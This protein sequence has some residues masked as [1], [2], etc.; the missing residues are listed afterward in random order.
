MSDTVHGVTQYHGYMW[1]LSTTGTWHSVPR[2]HGVAGEV[3]HGV[4]RVRQ[5]VVEGAR[6]REGGHRSGCGGGRSRRGG[7]RYADRAHGSPKIR[8]GAAPKVWSRCRHRRCS[9]RSPVPVRH[10]AP[11]VGGG[12]PS[13][14]GVVPL[15][16]GEGAHR[17]GT[18]LERRFRVQFKISGK[19]KP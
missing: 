13:S 9:G 8:I 5:A 18:R 11:E 3:L 7:R 16:V 17:T 4:P 14:G 2:V 15:A 6:R 19:L 12:G 1:L 10:V